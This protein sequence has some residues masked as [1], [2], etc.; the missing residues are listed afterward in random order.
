MKCSAW[1]LDWVGC[2]YEPGGQKLERRHPQGAGPLEGAGASKDGIPHG[3]HLQL[4]P[5]SCWA[6]PLARA[7]GHLLTW[8]AVPTAEAPGRAPAA[9]WL[10]PTQEAETKP[11][12]GRGQFA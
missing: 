10:M 7:A 3:A 12:Q 5:P 8:P 11:P 9:Q 6:E 2:P 1:C 4:R